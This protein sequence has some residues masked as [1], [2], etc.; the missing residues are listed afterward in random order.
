MAV[1]TDLFI[2]R[3][4]TG[5]LENYGQSV[6]AANAAGWQDKQKLSNVWPA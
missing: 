4:S 5:F 3:L 1:P 6:H 2:D